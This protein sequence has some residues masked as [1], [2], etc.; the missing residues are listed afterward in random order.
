M[1]Y[2]LA[3]KD[4]T[5]RFYWLDLNIGLKAAKLNNEVDQMMKFFSSERGKPVEF[6]L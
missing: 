5:V 1:H 6:S 2:P 3:L 4:S